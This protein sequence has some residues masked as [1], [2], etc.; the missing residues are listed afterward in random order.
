MPACSTPR[1]L[2]SYHYV[3]DPT[4][5]RT[6]LSSHEARGKHHQYR[7]VVLNRRIT[8]KSSSAACQAPFK[9]QVLLGSPIYQS[10]GNQIFEGDILTSLLWESHT[11][12]A[13]QFRRTLESD[14]ASSS[15]ELLRFLC[16]VYKPYCLRCTGADAFNISRAAASRRCMI[17][18]ELQRRLDAPIQGE[19]EAEGKNSL[20]DQ[21]NLRPP[22]AQENIAQE[23]LVDNLLDYE[24]FY[25]SPRRQKRP[26][27]LSVDIPPPSFFSNEG[28]SE[29]FPL[30]AQQDKSECSNF[31]RRPDLS[32]FN[33]WVSSDPFSSVTINKGANR[34]RKYPK[35]L[36][37]ASVHS[38]LRR[39]PLA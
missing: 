4:R 9:R 6:N 28:A 8:E 39:H 38:R 26:L 21:S 35:A 37:N 10:E 11:D 34:A 14:Y 7:L 2:L 20:G 15:D 27:S 17:S 32:M 5:H 3:E 23:L 13:E 19:R 29:A 25:S 31:P 12:E 24:D 1:N 33:A 16:D 36:Q 22:V 30:D 18:A